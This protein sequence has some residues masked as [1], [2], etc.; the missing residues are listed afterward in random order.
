MRP[1]PIR[2]VIPDP[3]QQSWEDMR[4]CDRGRFCAHC[5][6]TVIDFTTWSD[7]AL[8]N[9]FATN[10]G[11]VCGRFLSS[12]TNREISIP[13]QPH[14]RLYRMVVALGLSLLFVQPMNGFAQNK[15][16]RVTEVISSEKPDASNVAS[17]AGGAITGTVLDDKKE[18][19][20]NA[21]VQVF[22]GGILK[23]GN[24]TDFDGVFVIKP[25]DPGYYDV[26]VTYVGYDSVK[27]IKVP[28]MAGTQ[29]RQNFRMTPLGIRD[30]QPV[31][32][33]GSIRR[34]LI[35]RREPVKFSEED[36]KA[37]PIGPAQMPSPIRQQDDTLNIITSGIPCDGCKPPRKGWLRKHRKHN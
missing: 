7:A 21:T 37:L 6:K 5:Q 11:D 31:I 30:Q 10:P 1:E 23:G 26:L 9:F 36:I 29:T 22:Q 3:C 17:D 27:V 14:S 34:G 32:M 24:V 25:L 8:Y 2:I 20:L 33:G 35:E 12:Q 19:L 18:P 28:V 15:A 13:P 4:P 16:P